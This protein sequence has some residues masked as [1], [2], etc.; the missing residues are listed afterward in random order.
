MAARGQFVTDAKSECEQLM[1]SA[2]PMAKQMLQEH[3]EFFPFGLALNA[4]G[5]VVAVAP[6]DRREHPTSED[7]IRQLKHV[8]G[9][10]AKAGEFRAT[11]LIYDAR[12]QTS[13]QGAQAH[14]P[15]PQR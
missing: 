7:L 5:K 8:L 6:Y 12:L 13:A 10:Q 4:E 3:G 2:L 9:A 14:V 1:N 11:A 15:A